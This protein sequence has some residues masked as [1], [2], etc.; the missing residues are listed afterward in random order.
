MTCRST[1]LC[2]SLYEEVMLNP[3]PQCI[4]VRYRKA[5][6]FADRHTRRCR[7]VRHAKEG[8]GMWLWSP[9]VVVVLSSSMS[10]GDC[11]LTGRPDNVSCMIHFPPDEFQK[12]R[13][14]L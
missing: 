11:S 6:D 2:N 9:V 12:A 1:I 14:N 3:A 8:S 7:M 13:S 10:V 4:S 5:M